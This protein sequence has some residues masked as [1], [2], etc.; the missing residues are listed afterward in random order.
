MDELSA[1]GESVIPNPV[2]LIAGAERM[3]G[4]LVDVVVDELNV[5]VSEQM[6]RLVAGVVAGRSEVQ[7]QRWDEGAN[8]PTCASAPKEAHGGGRIDAIY[9]SAASDGCRCPKLTVC[10]PIRSWPCDA[11]PDSFAAFRDNDRLAGAVGKSAEA[12]LLREG[13][14]AIIDKISAAPNASIRAI[15]ADAFTDTTALVRR[16]A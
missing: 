7:V 12:H 11:W 6:A 1:V 5:S 15:V 14:T 10:P 4:R 9:R 2:T 13:K 8:R 16:L 3:V